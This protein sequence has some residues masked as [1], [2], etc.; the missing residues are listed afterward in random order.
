MTDDRIAETADD[1]VP[2]AP[3][4][5]ATGALKTLI[6][7]ALMGIA[8]IVPGV[9]GGT[10]LLALGLYPRFVESVADVTRLKWRVPTLV[11]LGMIAVAAVAAIGLASGPIDWGLRNH[12]HLMFAA[13][14]GLTLG[15]VPLL[16]R[17]IRPATP[18]AWIGMVAGFLLMV[19]IAMIDSVANLPGNWAVFVFAGILGSAAMVLPGISGSY[20]LLIFGVYLPV[21]TAIKDFVSALRGGAMGDALGLAGTVLVPVGIGVLIGI[22]GLANGLRAL[23]GRFPQA[24]LGVLLGLLVGSVVGLWPFANLVEKG[25]I[26][27]EAPAMTAGN[28]LLAL[29]LVAVGFATTTAVSRLGGR[30]E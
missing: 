24:T 13:F 16:W 25:E 29:V 27:A 30:R 9:S 18:A 19:A 23:L 4:P 7:G 10:M 6:G 21:V 17:E 2:A 3:P 1:A 22:A 5:G 11:F 28:V 15:G 12:H 8:N 14:I 20:L 26:I